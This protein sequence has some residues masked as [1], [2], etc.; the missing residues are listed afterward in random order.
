M[1]AGTRLVIHW[2]ASAP[3]TQLSDTESFFAIA[4]ILCFVMCLS[5]NQN[6]IVLTT[7]ATAQ[8][9]PANFQV[10][11]EDAPNAPPNTPPKI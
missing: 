11:F 6:V 7:S 3:S 4:A 1:A 9:G 10:L 5:S 2:E 8:S